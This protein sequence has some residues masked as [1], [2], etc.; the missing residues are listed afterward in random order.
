MEVIQDIYILIKGSNY[1]KFIF[2]FDDRLPMKLGQHLSI[3][4][5][6]R[7]KVMNRLEIYKT[8]VEKVLSFMQEGD[9]LNVII[10]NIPIDS[11]PMMDDTSLEEN[12]S[13]ENIV[14]EKISNLKKTLKIS[15]HPFMRVWMRDF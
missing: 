7:D 14:F 8:Q 12:Q 15:N 5:S 11:I 9:S 1:E 2:I 3:I 13:F 6:N 10:E 4:Q